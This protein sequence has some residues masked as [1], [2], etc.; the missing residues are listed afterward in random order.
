MNNSNPY[1]DPIQF[2]TFD[3]CLKAVFGTGFKRKVAGNV[4]NPNII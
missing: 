1:T 2:A 3:V 4:A